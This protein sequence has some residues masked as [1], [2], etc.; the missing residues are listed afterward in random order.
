MK[1]EQPKSRDAST[2]GRWQKSDTVIA[3]VMG[4]G[5]VLSRWPFQVKLLDNFDA[6]NYALALDHFDMRLHQPQPPGYPLYILLGRA[7]NLVFHDHLAAL[8]WLSTI[9]SGLGVVAIY[10]VGREMFGRRAGIIA[11]LLLTTSTVFWFQGEMASPY[12]TDLFASAIVG[13]LCYRLASSPGHV[14]VW[15]GA[16][17]VGLAGALR[18]QTIVFLFPLFLCALRN[19]SWKVIGG[20]VATAGI[21]FGAFFLP[22]VMTSGG[23]AA[24]ARSMRGLVPIFQS[25]ETLVRSTRWARFMRNAD[26]ILRYTVFALGELVIP[27][28]LVGYLACTH[29]LRI[30]RDSKLSFLT[31]WILPTWIVYFL[32]WPGNLGTILVCMPPFFLLAAAGLNWVM[33][34]PRWGTAVG[35]TLLAALLVWRIVIFTVLPQYPL[36]E[37]YR[38]FDNYERV[39]GIGDYYRSKLSL[40][41]EIP[42]EETIVYANDFRHLQYYLPQYR[43]FSPPSL[44]SSNPNTVEL[45]ISIEN[46]MAEAWKEADVTTLVPP[47]TERI[48]FFDLPSDM[49]FADQALV[50][51]R[52]GLSPSGCTIQVVSIPENYRALWTP[53]GLLVEANE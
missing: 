7:F 38:R 35:W 1:T 34:R 29:R 48:V 43:T 15:V 22:A 47:E 40:V 37:F 4:L 2:I 25:T 31:V 53:K 9:L 5:T 12:T 20:A 36:G 11:A 16:L 52:S 26:A 49:L 3:T 30:W 51:E 33:D 28:A 21:V 19:R 13:W 14:A 44:L 17:A 6:V 42:A 27:F 50:G 18:L 8:V 23:P 46:G 45:I 41:S 39:V 24:F 32:I 10:L